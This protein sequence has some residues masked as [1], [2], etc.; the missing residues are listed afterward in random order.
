MDDEHP[1]CIVPLSINTYRAKGISWR[2]IEWLKGPDS[3]F[4]G[5]IGQM[6]DSLYQA[7]IH[8]LHHHCPHSWDT[9]DLYPIQN[10]SLQT[11]IKDQGTGELEFQTNHY[12]CKLD[13]F[14]EYYAKK[15]RRFKKRMNHIRNKLEQKGCVKVIDSSTSTMDDALVLEWITR[16]SVS[17]WKT[18]TNTT[19][20]QQGPQQF[21]QRLIGSMHPHACKVWFLTLNDAPI[22]Y[23]LQCFEQGHVYALRSDFDESYASLSPGTYLN[24]AVCKS[25]FNSENHTYW[26]GP[27]ENA[28]KLVWEN[29][30][31]PVYR[32]RVYRGGIK[33]RLISLWRLTQ[34]HWESRRSSSVL[35]E[36]S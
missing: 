36:A 26:M 1:I 16:L 13:N 31:E 24:L 9:L 30:K 5:V 10:Q 23:E 27:G 8:E 34:K 20:D 35:K 19:F 17:S 4:C 3:H 7:F 25:L 15:S 22:A 21:I 32:L 18:S 6:S 2:Q 12:G 14:D 11:M 33:A 29:F 28:Y